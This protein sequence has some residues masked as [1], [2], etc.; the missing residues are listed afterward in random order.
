MHI[1]YCYPFRNEEYL[2]SPPYIGTYLA[3]LQEP[4]VLDTVNR[5]RKIM[6]PFSSLV[7]EALLNLSEG[8]ITSYNA[9]SQQEN[10][11]VEVELQNTAND[12]LDDDSDICHSQDNFDNPISQLIFIS[13]DELNIMIWSEHCHAVVKHQ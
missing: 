13:D 4:G 1:I 8:V 12:L 10:D 9:F 5:H 11:E 3:K 7:N 2:K 6:E